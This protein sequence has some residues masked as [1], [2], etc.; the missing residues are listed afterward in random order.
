MQITF[1]NLSSIQT[2]FRLLKKISN[3]SATFCNKTN[4]LSLKKA[5]KMLKTIKFSFCSVITSIIKSQTLKNSLFS[6]N[7]SFST[8]ITPKKLGS[9]QI[10]SSPSISKTIFSN[11]TSKKF[12]LLITFY[13]NFTIKNSTIFSSTSKIFA[14]KK[15][16]TI[17]FANYTKKQKTKNKARG[18]RFFT[19]T[20]SKT[21]D[22]SNKKYLKTSSE[23]SIK[24]KSSFIENDLIYE[25][26]KI[27]RH[28]RRN[29]L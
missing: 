19:I 24:I 17:S 28:F 2:N 8:S 27:L 1:T 18:F 6:I 29:H 11:L 26:T 20:S 4:S 9:F 21:K 12:S 13:T 7:T 16:F 3:L 22:C 25:K 10:K 5:P 23:L 15:K 14:K